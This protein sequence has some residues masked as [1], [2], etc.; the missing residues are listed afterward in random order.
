MLD[1]LVIHIGLY[2]MKI[3]IRLYLHINPTVNIHFMSLL[4]MQV[5]IKSLDSDNQYPTLDW[6]RAAS[7]SMVEQFLNLPI[8]IQVCVHDTLYM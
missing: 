7:R 3:H 1:Y 6:Q 4:S 8:W 5:C 2:S